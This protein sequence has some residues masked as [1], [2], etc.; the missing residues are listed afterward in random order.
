[1]TTRE[2]GREKVGLDRIEEVQISSATHRIVL[3]ADTYFYSSQTPGARLVDRVVWLPSRSGFEID[4]VT[5]QIATK[6][7]LGIG[8]SG[9]AL[10]YIK[11]DGV[12][13]AAYLCRVID[14]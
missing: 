7:E 11:E 13:K 4:G 2:I 10:N 8:R 14:A 5:Y 1:M 12:R 3:T 9:P 6:L